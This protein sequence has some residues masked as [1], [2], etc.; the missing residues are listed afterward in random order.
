MRYSNLLQNLLKSIFLKKNPSQP[1]LG[2]KKPPPKHLKNLP[3]YLLS[4]SI[5]IDDQASCAVARLINAT[6]NTIRATTKIFDIGFDLKNIF[7]CEYI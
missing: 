2:T 7:L 6:T 3:S 1:L 5:I 4:E